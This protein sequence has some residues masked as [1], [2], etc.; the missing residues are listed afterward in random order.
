MNEVVNKLTRRQIRYILFRR[1]T[2]ALEGVAA[3]DTPEALAV[4][5]FY[6]S[7][8]KFPGFDEFGDTWDIGIDDLDTMIL[9]PEKWWLFGI[10]REHI[11][12]R[13]HQ[14]EDGVA[15]GGKV[16]LRKGFARQ[17]ERD[18]FSAD[19]FRRVG[20]QVDYQKILHS[21]EDRRQWR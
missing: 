21:M 20:F 4:Y 18:G 1:K 9:R 11:V 19:E 7:Q 15:E 14:N 8:R 3:P 13:K 17:I 6:S 16:L 10:G 2:E 5:E 12:K